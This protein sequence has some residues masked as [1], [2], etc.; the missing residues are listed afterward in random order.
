MSKYIP[1]PN[2]RQILVSVPVADITNN[3]LVFT[4]NKELTTYAKRIVSIESFHAGQIAVTNKSKTV[5]NQAV[6]DKS[7]LEIKDGATSLRNIPLKVLSKQT[8]QN[9]IP[10]LNLDV[11]DLQ[12]SQIIVGSLAG[13]VALEEYLFFITYERKEKV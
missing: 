1:N 9:E 13:L 5:I 4:E 2:T 6:H 8:P 12:Q 7:F 10:I 3:T 11:I